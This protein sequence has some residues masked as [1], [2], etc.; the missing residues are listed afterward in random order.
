MALDLEAEL[1]RA[2]YA[3]LARNRLDA[4][5]VAE[6]VDFVRETGPPHLPRIGHRLLRHLVEQLAAMLVHAGWL[7]RVGNHGYA[8]TPHTVAELRREPAYLRD[9]HLNRCMRSVGI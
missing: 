8:L 4:F 2:A 1:L 3:L 5:T 7:E 6:L 9:A